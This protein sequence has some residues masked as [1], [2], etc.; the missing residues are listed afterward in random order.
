MSLLW[1]RFLCSAVGTCR[2]YINIT[3]VRLVANVDDS[4]TESVLWVPRNVG[5]RVIGRGGESINDLS[6]KTNSRIN[7]DLDT[8]RGRIPIT[9]RG[10]A[11][12][13]ADARETIE[14]IQAE[15]ASQVAQSETTV[16][17]P[18]TQAGVIIGMG[19]AVVKGLQ[20]D[21]GAQIGVQRDLMKDGL[22]PV[23]IRGPPEN[24]EDAKQRIEQRLANAIDNASETTV[25]VA[26][27]QLGLII[28]KGGATIKALS[29]TTA[30]YIQLD[31]AGI[32]DGFVPV[33]LKGEVQH[34][35]AAK[36]RIDE[37]LSES[38]Q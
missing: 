35:T 27:R 28:G 20:Q 10:T 24:V 2:R 18:K 12:A 33:T 29:K 32:K 4:L 16:W 26:E 3:A 30:A 17:I 8:V 25:W 9:I 6:M 13:C 34:C 7:V 38:L 37:L 14:R 21:T 23:I 22:I 5:F 36:Q 19:G 31:E 1:N 11:E 15:V